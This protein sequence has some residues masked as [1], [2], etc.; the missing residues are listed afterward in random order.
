MTLNDLK[1]ELSAL[2]FEREIAIDKSLILAVKRALSTVYTERSVYNAFSIEH[3][4]IMPT[5]VCKSLVHNPQCIESFTLS[6]KAYSFTA[7]GT[8][9]FTI[10]NGSTVK[11]YSF[12]APLYLWQDFISGEA[13]ITFS[14]DFSFEIFNLAVLESVRSSR[15]E[16][17]FAYGEPFEYRL[18]EI[19]NDFHSFA[20]LPTDA[21]GRE[22]ESA[23]LEGDKLLIPWGYNG[24]INLLYKVKAPEISIDEPDREIDMPREIEHLI[25][26]LASAYYWADDAPDK[27]EYYL[28][29]YRDAMKSVK[30]FNTRRLGGGYNN[31]TGW[32]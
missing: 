8:G 6:G 22:I 11:E 1:D 21:D 14:G 19:K 28:S 4:P 24:R 15:K 31:V 27:A 26:L 20:T 5:L 10:E 7:S 12:S 30:L 2:G 23:I 9:T 17:I 13:T 18:S 29:L 3:H 16:D 32:A 25:A